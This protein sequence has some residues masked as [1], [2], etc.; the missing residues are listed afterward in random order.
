MILL[1]Y[2]IYL[3]VFKNINLKYQDNFYLKLINIL[4]INIYIIFFYYYL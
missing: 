4:Y 1:R 3:F 2:I